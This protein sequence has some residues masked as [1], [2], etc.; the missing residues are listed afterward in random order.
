MRFSLFTE[1]QC[2]PGSSPEARLN[3]FI[4]QAELAERLGFRGFWIAEIHCQPRFSLLS[5]PYVVLGAVAQRTRRLRLGVAVNTLPVHHPV[6]LAEQAAMLDLISGGRMDF[7]AGGGH[8]HSRAY[9]C[10]GADHKSTHDIMVESLDII[11]KAW[12]HETLSYDGKYYRIP[13]IVVNPKPV[14]KPLPPFYMATSSLEGVEVGARIGINMFLPIHT[15]TPEQV[16]EYAAAYWQG[17]EKQSHEKKDRELGLL[18]P[19]HLANTTVEAKARSQAGIMSYFKII[20]DMRSDYTE[21]LTRR[22]AE[23][24][25]RLRTAAGTHVGF[26]T[27]CS[28]HA[29]VGDSETAVQAI[30]ELSRR[31]GA[32]HLLAWFNI[33]SVPHALVKQSMEQF[34]A[35]V[36]PKL[37]Q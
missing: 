4:E 24:P 2:P 35:E 28:Q 34:A 25:A 32:T 14:Q 23:L 1:I 21:W 36:M 30:R 15:R 7:A 10:F 13:E 31:T 33:G 16:A 19:M 8:P 18:A 6:H 11:R 27:I 17:L 5:A 26:E 9:E 3:E 22:G 29:I 20:A 12:S 37:S